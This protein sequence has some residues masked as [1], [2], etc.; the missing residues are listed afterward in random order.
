M[1]DAV[2]QALLAIP[3]GFVLRVG[4]LALRVEEI[5]ADAELEPRSGVMQDEELMDRKLVKL[6]P[7][8]RSLMNPP[9][10]DILL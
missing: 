7:I 2:L 9:I 6:S 3:K 5:V 4:N 1:E 8:F 10:S